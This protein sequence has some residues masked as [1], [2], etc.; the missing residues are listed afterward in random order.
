M[1]LERKVD[2]I[3]DEARWESSFARTRSNLVAAARKAKQEIIQNKAVPMDYEQ[4]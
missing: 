3:D 2:R 1:K 4:L